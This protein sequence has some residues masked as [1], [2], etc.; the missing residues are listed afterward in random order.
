MKGKI[1]I[2]ALA[3]VGAGLLV[4]GCGKGNETKTGESGGQK[5]IHIGLIAKSQSNPVFQAALV[6]ANDAA[7][8]LGPKYNVKVV[9]D[10]KSPPD[11]D[12][13]AQAQAIDAESRDGAA[14]IAI[15]CSNADAVKA[16]IEIGRAHV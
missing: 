11:E 1:S 8:E 4:G 5:T 7:N 9:I 10:W 6:G 3:L 16:N 14:G 2:L 15:S 12:A 13:L